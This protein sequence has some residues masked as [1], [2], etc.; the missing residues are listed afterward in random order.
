MFKFGGNEK[1]FDKK[2]L[3]QKNIFFINCNY[4]ADFYRNNANRKHTKS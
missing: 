3:K 1:L 2:L 4:F